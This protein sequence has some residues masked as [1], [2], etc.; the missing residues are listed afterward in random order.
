[1]L[2]AA[3]IP[4]QA[5][6]VNETDHYFCGFDSAEEFNQWT[7]INTNGVDEY[8]Y[9]DWWWDATYCGAYY[10]PFTSS[11]DDWII[12]P[13]VTLSGDKK[14][15]VKVKMLLE[16]WPGN[17]AHIVFTIG[18][19]ATVEA[20]SIDLSDDS[21]EAGN[22]YITIPLPDDI[23]AGT[24]HFGIH[25]LV[26]AFCGPDIIQSFEVVENVNAKI[27]VV[28]RNNETLAPVPGATVSL[29]STCYEQTDAT[30]GD[31]GSCTFDKLSTGTYSLSVSAD[32]Y[33]PVTDHQVVIA[34]DGT[35]EETID[36]ETV[37][38]STVSGKVVDESG[39]PEKNA[40]IRLDGVDIDYEV[41]TDENGEFTIE[42]VRRPREYDLTVSKDF[43][44][45]HRDKLVLTEE[46]TKDLGNIQLKDFVAA[47]AG[48]S[49]EQT[50]RG[51]FISWLMPM[52][53]RDFALDNG[54][55]AGVY[56]IDAP[57]YATVGVL[58]REP[59]RVSSLSWL[60]L[61][62]D[63][64]KVDV[65]VY[66]LGSDGS[67]PTKP[68][69]EAKGV[70]TVN[71]DY[72]DGFVWP[73]HV[74]PQPIDAPYGCIVAIGHEQSLSI[75]LDYLNNSSTSLTTDRPDDGWSVCRLSNFFIR[76]KG[77]PLCTDITFAESDATAHRQN[78]RC[79]SK[80]APR[81]VVSGNGSATFA[82]DIWRFENTDKETPDSWTSVARDVKDLY[83]ID[84][85]LS[86]LS[87]GTYHYAI[88][89]VYPDGRTSE[90]AISD[91]IDH[92]MLTSLSVGVNTN[93]AIDYSEGALLKAVNC[94]NPELVYEATVNGNNA[95]ISNMR[96]GTY[97][98]T[99]SKKGFATAA[100]SVDLTDSNSYSAYVTLELTP[101]A[102]F[103]L[104]AT[105][106]EATTDVV[107]EWNG[108]EGISEDCE[109]ME[110]F[111]INPA[112]NCQWTYIDADGENTYGVKQC[113]SSPYPNMFEPAAYMAFN[114]S[115]TTPSLLEYL[116]PHSGEK[117]L[118]SIGL[119]NVDKRN[120]DYMFSPE[121]SF[122]SE[123][124]L[125]FH[126]ASG[127][128]AALGDEE[129]MVGYT[130]DAPTAENVI[131]ITKEPQTVGAAWTKFEYEMPKEARHTVIRC[132]SNQHMFFMVD[133]IFIGRRE[134][135]TFNLTTFNVYLDDELQGN[136]AGRSISLAGLTTGKHIAKVQTVYP[137][138]DN[139]KTYSDF[140][141]L[142]FTVDEVSGV[143]TPVADVLYTYNGNELRPGDNVDRIDVYDMQG[144]LRASC[145]AGES[146]AT[147]TL[148]IG[149]YLIRITAGEN[150][151]VARITVK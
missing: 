128:Y 9:N 114:P 28:V 20:Q 36:I 136:T 57:T 144:R 51:M 14:C 92:Q 91:A 111:A 23:Q 88:Q 145:N 61:D 22:Y 10:H 126:A 110:D 53:E 81:R 60:A 106:A 45:S 127:F 129:F 21:Y 75:A 125:S 137:M 8:G 35:V 150:V 31:A 47:P 58:F 1:M 102:P 134:A 103:N 97:L 122:D 33:I 13:A 113:E 43:K 138:A 143:D 15:A 37:F 147:G 46:E 67:L 63:D 99:V 139:D 2:L 120:D 133:D 115:A 96:K 123:F 78:V 48:L 98:L 11:G 108:E 41:T 119:Q 121:L 130:T 42:E 117:M 148:S 7:K 12:S 50:N 146:V 62:I 66:A 49:A 17:K 3:C 85:D 77:N 30:T 135:E 72:K 71:Y 55:Y 112:G 59:M 100:T 89:T 70:T 38:Y 26:S 73:E 52:E 40:T 18:N 124:L 6:V 34:A 109:S 141:E 84:K 19:E 39:N 151:S 54:E 86:E 94:D 68:V 104:K 29:S 16:M 140:S 87:Q 4:M 65:Y 27:N 5:T 105:Q 90:F 69:Y 116:Q 101:L 76:A 142:M 118:V 32:G 83:Y 107:L 132:V 44:I 95:V 82:Y 149:V 93:T 74:L 25:S 131:W 24:Y 79:L 64:E 80:D 56:T